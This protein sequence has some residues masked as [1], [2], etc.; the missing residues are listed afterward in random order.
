[1]YRLPHGSDGDAS[2]RGTAVI[3][4]QPGIVPAGPMVELILSLQ[5]QAHR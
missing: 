2:A 1:L 3:G 4:G 5:V